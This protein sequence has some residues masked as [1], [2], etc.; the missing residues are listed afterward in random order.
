MSTGPGL[1]HS[2]PGVAG[3]PNRDGGQGASAGRGVG[4]DGLVQ[5]AVAGDQLGADLGQQGAIGRLTLVQPAVGQRH[6]PGPGA[7]G[8]ADR[9]VRGLVDLNVQVGEGVLQR[10]ALLGAMARLAVHYPPADLPGRRPGR[11]R[12]SRR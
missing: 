12:R 8:G 7:R 5:G 3:V 9:G 1:H 6:R 10:G 4:G 2:G 11:G